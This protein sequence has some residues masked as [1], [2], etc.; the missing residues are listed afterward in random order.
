MRP[1]T[2][3]V[4]ASAVASNI[5]K[6]RG[7]FMVVVLMRDVDTLSGDTIRELLDKTQKLSKMLGSDF[8]AIDR[9]DKKRKYSKTLWLHEQGRGRNGCCC[10][11]SDALV[12]VVDEKFVSKRSSTHGVVV[13]Q[14]SDAT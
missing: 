11:C 7:S 9:C 12:V 3:L 8:L 6:E 2:L 13:V 14:M 10:C 1:G 4:A 5:N